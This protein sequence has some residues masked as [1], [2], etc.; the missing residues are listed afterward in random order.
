MIAEFIETITRRTKAARQEQSAT[1]L[2]LLRSI[3]RNDPFPAD[4]AVVILEASGKSEADLQR[5]AEIMVK[6]FESAEAM[7]RRNELD[8]KLTTLQ[9][10]HD[11]SVAKWQTQIR[12]LQQKITASAEGVAALQSEISGLNYCESTLRDTCLDAALL[13]RESEL[14]AELRRIGDIRR[15]AIAARDDVRLS[16]FQTQLTEAEKAKESMTQRKKVDEARTAFQ[17]AKAEHDRHAAEIAEHDQQSKKIN[18][19]LERIRAAK[20]IP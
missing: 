4:Q 20:L 9:A 15:K 5:D 19:E 8:A 12:E 3:A 2:E 1:Y 14:M 16:Y 10:E 17:R 13:T 6:R 11:K 7:R 18:V